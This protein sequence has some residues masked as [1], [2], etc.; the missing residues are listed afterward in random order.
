MYLCMYNG[1]EFMKSVVFYVV[2]C[3]A[4]RYYGSGL[5]ETHYMIREHIY[6]TS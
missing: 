5:R 1:Y 3:C 6:G 2:L 4:W